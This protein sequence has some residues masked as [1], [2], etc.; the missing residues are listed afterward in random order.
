MYQYFLISLGVVCVVNIVYYLVFSKFVFSKHQQGASLVNE[1]SVLVCVKNQEELLENFLTQ[2]KKQSHPNYELVLINNASYDNTL[3]LLEA[4]AKDN[5]HVTIVD[6]KNNE[7]FWGS[8]KYALTLGIKKAKYKNLLF[9][10][11]NVEITSPEWINEMSKLYSVDKQFV[12]GYV[13]FK[14]T[15]GVANKILRYSRLITN[16]CNFGWA[17]MYKPYVAWENNLGYTSDLFFE[18]NGFSTHMS[19]QTGAEDL[20]VRQAVTTK[21]VALATSPTMAIRVDSSLK[22]W[23]VERSNQLK[24]YTSTA[25]F[26][27]G[28][29]YFSQ[30][31]F[32]IL[33]IISGVLFH[34]PLIYM[35]I[36]L[37]F[38]IVGLVIGKAAF[39]F[40]EKEVFYLFPLWEL[41]S[42]CL[43]IPIFIKNLFSK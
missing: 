16:L 36:G 25:K 31:L 20:F 19:E 40:S 22:E 28:L 29:L 5:S 37:R 6:V 18:N 14:K 41:L 15:K 42:V 26:T 34:E 13:N 2:I 23:I 43:Q 8:K 10:T 32:W 30:L 1:V 9:T 17:S 3:E 38:V 33:A 39:K 12:L 11:P 27:L 4:Y 35:L 7:A 24:H 21:N